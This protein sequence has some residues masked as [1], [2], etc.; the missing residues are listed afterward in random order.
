M[1]NYTILEHPIGKLKVVK[2]GWSWPG[3][4]FGFIWAVCK[5]MWALGGI[6]IA[7]FFGLGV[8]GGAAG[9]ELE[10]AITFITSIASLV[11]PI[12]FGLNG[13]YWQ[14]TN[15]KQRGYEFRMTVKAA[16]PEAATALFINKYKRSDL[17]AFVA[18]G[19]RTYRG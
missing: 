17:T 6:P 7:V 14:E 13:N 11:A 2:I 9:G 1:K 4:F 8:I 12:V 5:R 18:T 3:F 15:L 19:S 10:K 16:N